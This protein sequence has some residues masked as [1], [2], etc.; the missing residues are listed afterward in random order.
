MEESKTVQETKQKQEKEKK[1]KILT[2]APKCGQ[3]LRPRV[4]EEGKVPCAFIN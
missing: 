3:D 1:K 2:Y 4:N